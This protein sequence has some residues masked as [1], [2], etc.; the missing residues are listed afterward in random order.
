ML[1]LL[2]LLS[3]TAI[4]GFS[5]ATTATIQGVVHDQTGAVVPGAAITVTNVETKTASKWVSGPEGTFT[6]PFLQPGDYEI[7]AEKPG[8]KRSLRRGVTLS[9]AD[10]TRVDLTLEVGATSETV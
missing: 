8:F 9:V 5:Q 7:G 3:L 4:C 1:R 2:T 10:T 6:A